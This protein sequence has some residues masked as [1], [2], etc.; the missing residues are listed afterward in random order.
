[1]YAFYMHQQCTPPRRSP[2][3]N[4]FGKH[5]RAGSELDR[6]EEHRRWEEEMHR[7]EDWRCV[8]EDSRREEDRR[9]ADFGRLRIEERRRVEERRLLDG[10]HIWEATCISERFARERDLVE[11]NRNEEE[12]RGRDRFENNAEW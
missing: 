6:H 3:C 10:D 12:M 5:P 4:Y 1:M 11:K 2:P 9:V 8:D 7:E